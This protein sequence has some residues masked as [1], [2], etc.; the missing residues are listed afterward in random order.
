MDKRIILK[1]FVP[2]VVLSSICTGPLYNLLLF[3]NPAVLESHW[4]F[5]YDNYFFAN[6]MVCSFI[7]FIVIFFISMKY[8]E[9]I[10]NEQLIVVCI[11]LIGFCSIFVGLAWRWEIFIF[12]YLSTSIASAY[13]IPVLLNVVS[14][15]IH[16]EY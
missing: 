11:I 14:N 9:K 4:T 16:S 13:I 10:T 8:V 12:V 3:L 1:F 7:F 15:K 2:V 6:L 5:Y